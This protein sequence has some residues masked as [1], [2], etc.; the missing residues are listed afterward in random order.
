MRLSKEEIETIKRS[1]AYYDANAKVYL[2]GS[3]IDNYKKGGDIDL[4]IISEKIDKKILRKIR[5]D[6]CDKFGEQK[7]DII[8]DNGTLNNPFAKKIF[9]DVAII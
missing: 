7:I 3:R 2:F 9:K 8:V 4:L 5:N 6:F 1:V